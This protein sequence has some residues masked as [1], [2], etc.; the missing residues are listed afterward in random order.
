[1]SYAAQASQRKG[2]SSGGERNATG[3]AS[4]VRG[5]DSNAKAAKGEKKEWET[6]VTVRACAFT[7]ARGSFMLPQA[8]MSSQVES[9]PFG[10]D[11]LAAMRAFQ[12]HEKLLFDPLPASRS[13]D[14]LQVVYAYPNTYCVGITSL[15]YQLVRAPPQSVCTR[16]GSVAPA[17][18]RKLQTLTPA[19]T[20]KPHGA[21]GP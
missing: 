21:R 11:P 4:K 16:C 15:G 2:K 19:A 8:W 13:G 20:G 1:M 6:H 17:P 18:A 5:K 7:R 10:G 12:A 9:T 14:P 3:G